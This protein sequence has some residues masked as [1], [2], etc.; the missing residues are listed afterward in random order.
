MNRRIILLVAGLLIMAVRHTT[1]QF[2]YSGTEPYSVKWEQLETGN[3][4][5]IYPKGFYPQAD[6]LVRL[7]EKTRPQVD[8]SLS[9]NPKKISIILHTQNVI[10]NGFVTMAPRRMEL[11]TTPSQDDETLSWFHLLALHESRHVA[12]INK[13]NRG[14][15]R[16]FSYATGQ[17]AFGLPVAQ[18]PLWLIEGDAVVTETALSDNGRGRLPEFEMYLK[19]LH[20][21][22]V[23]HISYDKSYMGSFKDFIPDWYQL[24]YQIVAHS[25]IK[26]GPDI[27]K[28]AF[29][30]IGFFSFYPF[31]LKRSLQ[32]NYNTTILNIYNETLDSLKMHWKEKISE[33]PLS[34]FTTI[35]IGKNRFYSNYR[36]PQRSEN[37]EIIVLKSSIDDLTKIIRIDPAGNEHTL[38]VPGQMF[39]GRL[40][41]AGNMIV[42]DEIIPDPRWE[43]RNYSVI[44]TFDLNTGKIRQ[45]TSGTKYFSPSLSPDANKI[46]VAETSPENIFSLV[47]LDAATGNTILRVQAPENSFLQYPDWINDHQIVITGTS[48]S[49]KAIYIFDIERYKWDK[50]YGPV[51]DNIFQPTGWQHYI[52][53]RT[54]VSGVDN[55]V[56]LDMDTKKLFQITT[57][58]FGAF[59]PAVVPGSRLVYSNYT[60]DGFRPVYVTIDSS[61][62]KPLPLSESINR[63]LP[64]LLAD[65]ELDTAMPEKDSTIT[66]TPEPY[67][68]AA[69]LF[70]LHSWLPFYMNP[71]LAEVQDLQVTPGFI[72]LSQ[73]KLSTSIS[74]FGLSYENGHFIAR[75]Q[76]TYYGFY[77]VIRFSASIGGEQDKYRFPEGIYPS[78]TT[79][80]AT[81]ISLGSYIPLVFTRGKYRTLI[82]PEIQA[83]FKNSQYYDN[84]IKQ[85]MIFLYYRLAAFRYLRTSEKDLYPKWGQFLNAGFTHTPF[86]RSQHGI[87]FNSTGI[88]Y[89]PGLFNHHSLRFSGYLQKQFPA[90]QLFRFNRI[91]LPRG[92][93]HIIS[94]FLSDEIVRLSCDYALPLIYPDLSVPSVLYIKRI[95]GNAFVDLA[96]AHHIVEVGQQITRK[97]TAYYNSVGVD[98]LA[99][100]HVLRFI[101]PFTVG[102]R[103][104][105]LPQ[106][107]TGYT[108]LIFSVNT[109]IL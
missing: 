48:Y 69:K 65:Q 100:F 27:W 91:S 80:I 85:G 16:L 51:K 104:S 108:G 23:K 10:S 101:F 89:V 45:I 33:S 93:S 76:L 18:T 34:S 82:R 81:D 53:Y 39:N 106:Y 7:F 49:G 3:F 28:N 12:Q 43:Q 87:M 60:A 57:S 75:P 68:R 20:T 96:Y 42:W 94:G 36:Y 70:N 11:V 109:S 86:E 24:G 32:E 84:G 1:A 90:D 67:R 59:D 74:S 38:H 30:Y 6:T 77:P 99:D 61:V 78:D 13:L 14:F 97:S 9:A 58:K 73:N 5:V 21:E 52:I 47:I 4:Q 37:G 29:E 31:S 26:Y 72:V 55:I 22:S 46:A 95:S 63:Q 35:S 54:G 98:I 83:E 41:V 19:A 50:L 103:Y 71:S 40:T 25:R 56:A 15:T 44:K 102:I 17:S 2:Y 79:F 105:Y 92:Y 8:Y 62:W 107:R 64:D 66:Y 88:L